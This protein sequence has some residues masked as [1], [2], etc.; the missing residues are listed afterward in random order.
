MLILKELFHLQLLNLSLKNSKLFGYNFKRLI[1]LLEK[2][3]FLL[4]KKVFNTFF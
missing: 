4:F 2:R 3:S 1:E